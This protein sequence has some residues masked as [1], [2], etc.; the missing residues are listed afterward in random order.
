M[1][2]SHRVP[3]DAQLPSADF[4]VPRPWGAASVGWTAAGGIML[5]DVQ[6]DLDAPAVRRWRD[7]FNSAIT[8]GATGVTVDLRGCS[9]IEVGCLSML[10]A[11]SRKLRERGDGGINL[12]TVPWSSLERSVRASAAKRLP[13]YSSAGEALRSLRHAQAS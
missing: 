3:E 9:A 6:G 11:T 5:V 1:G 2:T 13:R 7:L 8:E 10:A 12:V 4:A